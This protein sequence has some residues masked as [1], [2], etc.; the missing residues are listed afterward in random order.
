MT[1]DQIQKNIQKGRGFAAK[2]LGPPHDVYRITSQDDQGNVFIPANKIATAVKF[3]TKIAYGASI[4]T[5]FEGERQQGILWY[6]IIADLT[7][8]LVG[9]IVKLNDPI[10]GAG[11]SSVNFP[12]EQF[13]G[14]AIADNS[15]LKKALGGRLS[16]CINIF[17]LS[18]TPTGDDWSAT[19]KSGRPVVVSNG[20]F[21]L[22]DVGS[23]PC[24]IPAGLMASG[25]SYGDKIVDQV[26]GLQ[27][28]SGWELYLPALNGFDIREGDRVQGPDGAR[29]VVIVPYTQKV[30]ATGS[31]WF[32]ER[33]D[34]GP[35]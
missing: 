27:R 26:P 21:S 20:T 34:A 12:N 14:F 9:D 22:G 17:R 19:R 6:E 2:E 11:Y 23:T 3:F 7:N 28:K 18:E 24:K 4:R 15:P 10:Y 16:C 1:Y 31:Q 25:K 13:K 35:G 32:L 30:G 29:Y 33:E 5:S 8:Y